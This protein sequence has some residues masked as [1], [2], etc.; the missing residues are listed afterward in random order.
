M[1]N[2]G[3]HNDV[4]YYQVDLSKEEEKEVREKL[5]SARYY[6]R[7]TIYKIPCVRLI[8]VS[9]LKQ[10]N[11]IATVTDDFNSNKR[12]NNKEVQKRVI[13]TLEGMHKNPKIF[14]LGEWTE[15]VQ[16]VADKL[17]ECNFREEWL[18]NTIVPQISRWYREKD[19]KKIL[20]KIEDSLKEIRSLENTLVCSALK[21]AVK[22]AINNRGKLS[23]DEA[24]QVANLA[25]VE[26]VRKFNPE[27]NVKFITYVYGKMVY[28][29]KQSQ[30]DDPNGIIRIPAHVTNDKGIGS[31]VSLEED[32]D[33]GRNRSISEMVTDKECIPLEDEIDQKNIRTRLKEVLLKH[34][35]ENEFDIVYTR[36]LKEN[37]LLT[38]QEI[39]DSMEPHLTRERIRQIEERA[40]NRLRD[41]SIELKE[42]MEFF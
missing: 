2:S 36:Y 38:F 6:F 18:V 23:E 3:Y 4:K 37:R 26:A 39:S 31:W 20:R 21:A 8:V 12:G 41:S 7:D 30:M 15:W 17:H 27:S 16:E 28:G 10:I 19:L 40:L 25:L 34:L 33:V 11:S 5:S 1:F 35:P 32:V 24:I 9:E 29:M 42:L 14:S 22:I 13:E